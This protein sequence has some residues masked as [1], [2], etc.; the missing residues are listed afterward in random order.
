MNSNNRIAAALYS[1]RTV[2]L[3]NTGINTRHKG[4]DDDDGD[5]NDDDDNNNN[6]LT[7]IFRTENSSLTNYMNDIRRK[8]GKIFQ[9][10]SIINTTC[11]TP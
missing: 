6:T 1:L 3:R 11:F 5:D 2:C 4:D 9:S 7:A 8:L 10:F